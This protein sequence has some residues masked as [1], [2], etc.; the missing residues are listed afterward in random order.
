LHKAA[1]FG[2]TAVLAMLL[3]RAEMDVD[4]LTAPVRVPEWYEAVRQTLGIDGRGACGGG[5]SVFY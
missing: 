3:E 1:G 2:K 5:R 4:C